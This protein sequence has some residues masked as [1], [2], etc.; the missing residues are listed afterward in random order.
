MKTRTAIAA[1]MATLV[2]AGSFA[3]ALATEGGRQPADAL[4]AAGQAR[5]AAAGETVWS[6][7][8]AS[9]SSV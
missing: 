1:A 5:I 4:L 7:I 8:V 2:T 9:K 3:A 6:A